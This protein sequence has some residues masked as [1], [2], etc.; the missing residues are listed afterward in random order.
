[1]ITDLTD[2]D[3]VTGRAEQHARWPGVTFGH[4]C[5]IA[6]DAVIGA[7]TVLRNHVEIRAGVK[8]GRDCYLDSQVVLT[9]NAEV[10]DGV[11]L[12]LG[13]IVARGRRIGDGSYLAPRVMFN[14]VDTERQSVGGAHVGARG[15]IGTRTVLHHGITVADGTTIGAMSFVNRDIPPDTSGGRV[16]W[17]GCP[18]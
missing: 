3:F 16:L 11:T 17:V 13:V 8:I 7:G 1:M 9:G 6:P 12:R 4:G 18:A 2:S 14:D 10:G 5:L 15:F